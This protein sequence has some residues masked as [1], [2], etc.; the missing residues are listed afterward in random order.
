MKIKKLF[1]IN[2]V[3]RSRITLNHVESNIK[4]FNENKI[5][6]QQRIIEIVCVLNIINKF[7][8]IIH[9]QKKI[10]YLKLTLIHVFFFDDRHKKIN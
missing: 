2:F 9:L 1:S 8:K 3:L 10:I 7:S 4:N 5:Q 6:N